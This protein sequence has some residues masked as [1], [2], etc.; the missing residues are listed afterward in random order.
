M[1]VEEASPEEAWP[2]SSDGEIDD[3][4]LLDDAESLVTGAD[5]QLPALDAVDEQPQIVAGRMSEH[6]APEVGTVA[7]EADDAADDN[8][9]SEIAAIFTEEATELLDVAHASLTHWSADRTNQ[10]VALELKRALHT[11]KGGARMAG[12]RAMGD[13]SHEL[14]S[15]MQ[16]VE[17][18]TIPA[19]QGVFDVLEA[20]LDELH[21]MRDTVCNGGR[22][23]AARELLARIRR[24]S[25]GNDAPGWLREHPLVGHQ[26]G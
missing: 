25:G 5:E 18:G 14:E 21:R 3:A 10:A 7:D 16:A 19:S 1:V 26:A 17:V 22:C 2:D 15:C 20:A 9:D 12:I 23:V 24:L 4:L 13:L 11:I 6:D 8:F